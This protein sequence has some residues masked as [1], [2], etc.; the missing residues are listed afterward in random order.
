MRNKPLIKYLFTFAVML[1]AMVVI[2]KLPV[3][4]ITED[5]AADMES[6]YIIKHSEEWGHNPFCCA[7]IDFRI[8]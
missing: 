6:T 1:L 2:P 8:I 4:A 3:Y 7:I 5:E